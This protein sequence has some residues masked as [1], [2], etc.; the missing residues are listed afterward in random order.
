MKWQL[1][2]PIQYSS[3]AMRT[4]FSSISLFDYLQLEMNLFDAMVM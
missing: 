3:R 2:K 4:I 1:D